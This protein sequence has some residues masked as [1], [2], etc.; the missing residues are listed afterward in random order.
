MRISAYQ[1]VEFDTL[2]DAM[3]YFER[4]SYM[5]PTAD[6]KTIYGTAAPTSGTW[7][8]GDICINTNP[9]VDGN[10]MV[11]REWLCTVAGTP[12]T[13]VAQYKGFQNA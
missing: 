10:N 12:G 13:W 3:E 11:L 4:G 9:S 7:A 2:Y 6:N 8:L 1:A 5:L